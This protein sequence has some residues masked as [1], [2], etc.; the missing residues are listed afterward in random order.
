MNIKKLSSNDDLLIEEYNIKLTFNGKRN[1]LSTNSLNGGYRED[2]KVVFNND[3]SKNKSIG[4]LMK[5]KTIEEHMKVVAEEIGL[6]FLESTGMCTSA[7]M[8]NASIKEM[9]Y[10]EL[11]VT[12][13]IT[14]GID[15]NGG[16]AGDP[17]G[18][19][20]ENGNFIDLL[21]GTINIILFIDANLDENVLAGALMTA[22]EAKVVAVSELLLPS[23]YSNGIATGSGT[24]KIAVVGN[25]ESDFII[26]DAGKH[27][28]LGELIGLT[29]IEG[30]KE[31]LNLQT[32]ANA[33]TQSNIFARMDRF[34]ITEESVK[35]KLM[36]HTDFTISHM[37]FAGG[38]IEELN[39]NKEIVVYSSLYAHL[40]DQLQWDLLQYHETIAPAENILSLMYGGLA[41]S[42]F[43]MKEIN[44]GNYLE[45]FVDIFETSLVNFINQKCL[46]KEK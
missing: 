14:A 29:V 10:K 40:I 45:C 27:S 9:S 3:S 15:V 42:P 17:S 22:T 33:K 7:Q 43:D 24:D 11:T 6:N 41:Y 38:I 28:K 20:E 34:G 5:G 25:M 36:N 44:E 26:S 31:A 39:N 23:K 12:A 8:K 46:E 35:Q 30:I 13:I 2:L 21:G 16:R 1:V 4:C 19:Y 18:W 32:D 37:D